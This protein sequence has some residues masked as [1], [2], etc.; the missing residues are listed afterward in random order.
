MPGIDGT[1]GESGV[2]GF[3]GL[4]GLEGRPGKVPHNLEVFTLSLESV[5]KNILLN[6]ANQ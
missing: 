4:P 5:F 2:P 1:K 6:P 3:P